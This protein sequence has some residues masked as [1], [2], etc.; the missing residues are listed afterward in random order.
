VYFK[1]VLNER[2]GCA[3]YVIASRKTREAAVI[4]PAIDTEPYEALL[5][6]R[7][8]RL[9]YVIDTHIHADHVS[10]ARR[11]AAAHEA[12]LCL[13]E[14]AQV[15]YP[16]R[17]LRDGSELELGQLRLRVL[18]TPGHRPELISILIVNPPRSPEPSMVLT[19]DSLLV[20]DVGRPDFGGGDAAAQFDSLT[21][22]LRLPDWVAVFPGHFEGPCGKGMCGRPSTTLGFER[23]YNPLARLDRTQF[24][25]RLTQGMPPRPLNMTAIEA[26]NRSLADMPWAMLTDSPPVRDVGV[27]ELESRPPQ[28]GLFDV[29]EPEEYAPGHV[30]G[31]VNLPQADLA[32]RLAE[33]PRDRPVYLIC[34][35]GFRSLRAAQFLRQQGF[36][37]VVSVKGGTEAWRAAGKPLAQ[38]DARAAPPRV[39][40]TEW[41]HAGASTYVI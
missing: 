13:H 28:A 10:G 38:G 41:T 21:R 15:T 17:P 23:L 26:T 36:E 8:F 35:G 40:D 4:D 6:E 37:A 32:T 2:C 11:L 19:G 5:R 29:R 20:G 1:Q 39:V 34:Q 12:E 9:R 18:H 33:V 27:E 31:A 7:D 24:V 22:L 30:P 3:S 16:F 25:A 14:A